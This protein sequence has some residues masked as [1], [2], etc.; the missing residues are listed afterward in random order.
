MI[1][2]V[3]DAF[4]FLYANDK[5]NFIIAITPDRFQLKPEG[6]FEGWGLKAVFKGMDLTI[7]G[8]EV[9]QILNI[10][11]K[12]IFGIYS[13]Q[14]R[15]GQLMTCEKLGEV[16][17]NEPFYIYFYHDITQQ[18]KIG[19]YL[20]PYFE[21]DGDDEKGAPHKMTIDIMFAPIDIKPNE[22]IFKIWKK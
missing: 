8:K 20:F 6:P 11:G 4:D 17:P 21:Q 1:I 12:D 14:Y 13:Y 18:Y 2:Y 9:S 15:L 7:E 3:H 16:E 22:P 10:N 5:E 19:R